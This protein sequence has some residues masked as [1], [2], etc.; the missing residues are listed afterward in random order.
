MQHYSCHTRL[1]D[2]TTNPL[3]ALYF[4]C[5][6]YSA[7]DDENRIGAVY[8]FAFSKREIHYSDSARIQMLAHLARMNDA[9][10]KIILRNALNKL[11]LSQNNFSINDNDGTYR[12]ECIEKF[13]LDICNDIKAFKREIVPFDLLAPLLFIPPKTNDRIKKKM[14]HLLYQD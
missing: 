13:Y 12:N 8:I 4:A 7:E 10:K 5:K 11:K 6:N 14:V 3:V 1:L 9:E 2:I